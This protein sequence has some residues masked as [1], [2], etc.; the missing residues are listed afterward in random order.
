MTTYEWATRYKD[1]S[2]VRWETEEVAREYVARRIDYGFT[3]PGEEQVLSRAVCE[4][5]EAT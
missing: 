5:K 2:I 1:G 3:K 4:W